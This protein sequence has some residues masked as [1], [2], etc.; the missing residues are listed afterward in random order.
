[1][2][3]HELLAGLHEVLQPRT[4]FEIGVRNGLS[5]EL[6][7]AR[8]V[9]VDPF[10]NLTK[11][12]RCDLHLVRTTSDEFFARPHPFAHF[13]DPV[14]DLAFIDGMHLSEF[15]LRDFI[16]TEKFCGPGSVVVFDDML[17][18]TVEE[19][20]R[21]RVGA[22]KNGAWAGDVYKIVESMRSL[23]PDLILLEMDTRPTGT[24]VVLHPDPLNRALERAYDDLVAE[25]VVPDPQVVPEPVLSRSRAMTGETL[26]GSGVWAEIRSLRAGSSTQP[27][28]AVGDAYRRFGLDNGNGGA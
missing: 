19:A 7:R 21:G 28:T 26:L 18:R 25:Y 1:M 22:A 24:L 12:V 17:P 15:A 14:V 2:R 5:L 9:A 11:E 13:D 20:G 27:S 23:R 10:Y 8:S 16:N 4:Y 3:R 6:S